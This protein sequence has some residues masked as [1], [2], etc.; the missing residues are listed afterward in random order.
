MESSLGLGLKLPS[1]HYC[2]D[3]RIESAYSGQSRNFE[4]YPEKPTVALVAIIYA[5]LQTGNS[6]SE[7]LALMPFYCETDCFSCEFEFFDPF[8][9]FR[10]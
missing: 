7:Q 10:L 1:R 9:Y 5:S 2:I 4:F 8:C 3:R 6:R